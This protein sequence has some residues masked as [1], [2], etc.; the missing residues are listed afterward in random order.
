[1]ALDLWFRED[2]QRILAALASAGEAH[3]PEYVKALADVG[4]AFGVQAPGNGNRGAAR[5][6]EAPTWARGEVVLYDDGRQ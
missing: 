5:V 6:I 4:L 1:M 2:I 3:G